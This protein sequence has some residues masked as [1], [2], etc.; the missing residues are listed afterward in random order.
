M[1]CPGSL[2][3]YAP[4]SLKGSAWKS[5]IKP[6][7]VIVVL[8]SIQYWYRLV[9]VIRGNGSTPPP[10]PPFYTPTTIAKHQLARAVLRNG[11]GRG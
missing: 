8:T 1:Y 7:T 11:G 4:K 5:F 6:H 2:Y 3:N 10:F 9:L